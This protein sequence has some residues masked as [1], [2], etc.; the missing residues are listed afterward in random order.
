MAVFYQCFLDGFAGTG[1]ARFG[2]RV[3]IQKPGNFPGFQI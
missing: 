3:K 2:K 1:G